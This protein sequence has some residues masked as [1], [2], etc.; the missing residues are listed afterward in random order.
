MSYSRPTKSILALLEYRN[1]TLN[2]FTHVDKGV[3]NR[4]S[5]QLG[6]TPIEKSVSLFC[7]LQLEPELCPAPEQQH[8][9]QQQQQQQQHRSGSSQSIIQHSSSTTCSSCHQQHCK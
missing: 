9:L 7:L 8:H 6:S 1:L 3:K 5:L 4:V 2:N